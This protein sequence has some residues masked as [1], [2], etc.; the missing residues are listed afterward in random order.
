MSSGLAESE[1]AGQAPF[2]TIQIQESWFCHRH[3]APTYVILSNNKNR[4]GNFLL[5][6]QLKHVP[7]ITGQRHTRRS[8]RKDTFRSNNHVN[9]KKNSL[10]FI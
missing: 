5:K 1:L 9:G 3:S 7:R 8:V 2:K 4:L 10:H 6:K